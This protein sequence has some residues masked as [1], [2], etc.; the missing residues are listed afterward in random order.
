MLAAR[1]AGDDLATAIEAVTDWATFAANIDAAEALTRAESFD[2]LDEA[3]QCYPSIRRYAPVLLEVI[4]FQGIAASG[5]VLE[6]LVILRRLY[7][8]EI[9]KVPVD[10]PVSFVRERW[11]R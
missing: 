7:T 3:D 10:A 6:A 4:E 11:E 8:G 9:R 2:V 5:P 1:A